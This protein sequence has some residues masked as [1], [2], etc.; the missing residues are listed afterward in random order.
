MEDI[1][2][3]L[4]DT[5]DPLE[6]VPADFL[7]DPEW[8]ESAWSAESDQKKEITTNYDLEED[9]EERYIEEEPHPTEELD[10]SDEKKP[11]IL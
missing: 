4:E 11:P 3:D 1:L 10:V 2:D 6:E 8:S 7:G 9:E 5:E